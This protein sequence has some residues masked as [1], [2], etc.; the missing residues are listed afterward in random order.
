MGELWASPTGWRQSTLGAS[1]QGLTFSREEPSRR[2][3]SHCGQSSAGATPQTRTRRTRERNRGIIVSSIRPP[4][5]PD[6]P[7]RADFNPRWRVGLVWG[8]VCRDRFFGVVE[9]VV[10]GG[11][12]PGES[13]LLGE[14][15]QALQVLL[16]DLVPRLLVGR[17]AVVDATTERARLAGGAE[18]ALLEG[19]EL[20]GDRLL[21][22]RGGMQQHLSLEAAEIEDV[23]VLLEA[24]TAPAG[25]ADRSGRGDLA[26]DLRVQFHHQSPRLF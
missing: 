14:F 25:N 21:V 11:V 26:I 13:L 9:E 6:A 20:R 24:A 15:L 8:F 4:Y 3:P 22:C 16:R 7:A 12:V 10:E 1:F 5:K 2:G 23:A 18:V 19:A 17:I